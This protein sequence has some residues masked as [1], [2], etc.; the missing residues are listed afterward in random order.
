MADLTFLEVTTINAAIADT[1]GTATGLVTS[2]DH[3]ELTEQIPDLPLLQ[4]YWLETRTDPTSG[5]AQ[6]SFRGA[7]R[8]K[9]LIFRADLFARQ[10][11][12]IA[13]DMTELMQMVSEIQRVL[14][15]EKEDRFGLGTAV[16]YEDW[17]G[18]QVDFQYDN[19]IYLGARFE[20][21]LR[22]A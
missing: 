12:H 13:E 1:L 15:A 5:T 14:E 22:I 18:R 21:K 16:T 20:I 3:T 4:C 2:Q 10:R 6:R 11:S 7:V 19:Y 9:S 17:F 8:E